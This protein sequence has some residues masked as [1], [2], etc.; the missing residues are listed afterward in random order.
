[1]ASRAFSTVSTLS[2]TSCAGKPRGKAVAPPL[3]KSTR[4]GCRA[5]RCLAEGQTTAFHRAPPQRKYRRLR[6]LFLFR[7]TVSTQVFPKRSRAQSKEPLTQSRLAVYG[8]LCLPV[9]TLMFR[10]LSTLTGGER[11]RGSRRQS[12][13]SPPTV[14]RSAPQSHKSRECAARGV[15]CILCPP[16]PTQTAVK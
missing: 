5:I 2:S 3:N 15:G 11:E 6:V 14:H 16:E 12:Q 13:P 8:C 7:D 4:E 9:G 1:M 10:L